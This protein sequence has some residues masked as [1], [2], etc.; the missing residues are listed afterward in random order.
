MMQGTVKFFN[1]T[2][3]FGF[4]KEAGEGNTPEHFIHISNVN[5]ETLMQDQAVEFEIREGRNGKMEAF[6]ISVIG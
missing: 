3:G 2:K 5:G 1:E 6:N 4:I